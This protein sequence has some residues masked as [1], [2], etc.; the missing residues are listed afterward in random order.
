M[1]S[2]ETIPGPFYTAATPYNVMN[3]EGN[4]KEGFANLGITPRADSIPEA[5]EKDVD[6]VFSSLHRN[7]LRSN[8]RRCRMNS[9][10]MKTK[11]YS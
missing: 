3:V 11:N 8:H 4:D 9:E 10:T 6:E 7:F 5:E 2:R 1:I